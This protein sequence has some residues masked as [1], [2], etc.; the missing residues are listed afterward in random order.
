[1]LFNWDK[2]NAML[3]SRHASSINQSEI[4]LTC[5]SNQIKC[6]DHFELLGF[7]MDRNLG[8]EKHAVEVKKKLNFKCNLISSALSWQFIDRLFKTFVLPQFEY[9]SSVYFGNVSKAVVLQMKKFFNYTSKQSLH[10]R[11]NRLDLGKKLSKLHLFDI[12]P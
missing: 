3:I 4:Q 8:F 7:C 2:T 5:K 11:F 9:C 10:I 1:M 6:I 12:L